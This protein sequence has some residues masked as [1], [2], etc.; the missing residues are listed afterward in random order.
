MLVSETNISLGC[1]SKSWFHLRHSIVKK[2]QRL[3]QIC[4]AEYTFRKES[5]LVNFLIINQQRN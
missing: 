5:S 2:N 3:K 1:P 4:F